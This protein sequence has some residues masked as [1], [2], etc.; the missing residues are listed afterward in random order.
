MQGSGLLGTVRR[1]LR[2]RGLQIAMRCNA[3][4]YYVLRVHDV[5]HILEYTL[6]QYG[7]ASTRVPALKAVPGTKACTGLLQYICTVPEYV[8][9]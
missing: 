6:L 1:I 4:P 7:I 3:I 5:R 2:L 9:I 8:S